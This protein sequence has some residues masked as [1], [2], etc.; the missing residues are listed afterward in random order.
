MRCNGNE[1]LNRFSFPDWVVECIQKTSGEYSAGS[2]DYTATSLLK[3]PYLKNL[4]ALHREEIV[5]DPADQV[6]SVLGTAVHAQWEKCLKSNPRYIVE[7]RFYRE[8]DGYKIGGQIDLY[9]KETKTLWDTK[10]TSVYKIIKSDDHFDFEGQLA[11]NRWIMQANGIQVDRVAIACFINDW[12]RSEARRDSAYPQ[13]RFHEMHIPLWS[14]EDTEKFIRERIH[15]HEQAKRGFA[16]TCSEK[17]RWSRPKSFRV[18]KEGRKTAVRVLDNEPDAIQLTA[19]LG[20]GHSV[21]IREGEDIRCDSYCSVNKWCSRY[22]SKN[23][24]AD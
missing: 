10:T 14:F 8:I 17:E 4:E 22:Q 24:K 5:V 15:L 6:A 13:S 7:E 18:L 11:T 1:Q 12:R 3:P 21:E 2:S 16:A 23:G 20:K 9:D 19:S